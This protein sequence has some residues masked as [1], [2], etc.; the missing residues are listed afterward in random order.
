MEFYKFTKE[1][2]KNVVVDFVSQEDITNLHSEVL[3]DRFECAKTIKG[4]LGFHSY[5]SIPG[6]YDSV[7]VKQFDK[8]KKYKKVSVTKAK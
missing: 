6:C 4:T 1:K 2:F 5:S 3:E 8:S 7:I